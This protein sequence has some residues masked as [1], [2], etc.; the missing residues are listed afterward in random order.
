MS[1]VSASLSTIGHPVSA[2]GFPPPFLMWSPHLV[3]HIDIPQ[4][5]SIPLTLL[6]HTKEQAYPRV[7]SNSDLM[8][9]ELKP[10][11]VKVLC[12]TTMTNFSHIHEFTIHNCQTSTKQ[13][14]V[15]NLRTSA[16]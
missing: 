12:R 8:L 13:H 10:F 4:R 6:F 7:E 11:Q 2:C 15:Y 1:T 5:D 9:V 14:N 16:V 3:D